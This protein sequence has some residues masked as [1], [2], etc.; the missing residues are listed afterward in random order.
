MDINVYNM[1]R[2]SIWVEKCVDNVIRV[3]YVIHNAGA[4]HQEITWFF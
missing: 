2:Q 3:D 4:T 1:L